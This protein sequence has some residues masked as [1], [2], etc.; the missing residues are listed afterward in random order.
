MENNKITLPCDIVRDLLPLYHDGVASRTSEEAVEEHLASC[1]DCR[2][3]YDEICS[4]LP[5][6]TASPKKKFLSMVKNQRRLKHIM[7]TVTVLAFCTA[8]I[9]GYFLQLQFPIVRIPDDDIKVHQ[10]Y[11]YENEYGYCYFLMTEI[12]IYGNMRVGF[13]ESDID[14]TAILTLDARKPLI[15]PKWPGERR[16]KIFIYNPGLYSADKKN[17]SLDLVCAGGEF[18][19]SEADA[20]QPVPEYVYIWDQMEK[21]KSAVT[22]AGF[23]FEAGTIAFGFEDGSYQKWDLDGNLIEEIPAE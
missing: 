14:G 21:G 11:R 15:S 8:L 22:D 12:A 7:I 18:V 23:D 2:Q 4:A 10:V 1:E 3:E 9:A 17:R 13:E 5:E 6:D 16:S 20:D 19:W